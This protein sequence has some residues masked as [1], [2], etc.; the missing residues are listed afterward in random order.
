MLCWYSN[1]FKSSNTTSCNEKN[2]IETNAQV[3][4]YRRWPNQVKVLRTNQK[5][6]ITR[7]KQE[8]TSS[9][10]ET[11]N[12]IMQGKTHQFKGKR[13]GYLTFGLLYQDIKRILKSQHDESRQT[14]NNQILMECM[15]W[16]EFLTTRSSL[17]VQINMWLLPCLNSKD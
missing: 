10:K 9:C 2:N 6:K 17:S 15:S 16:N 14:T 12:I 13:R 8:I 7:A 11:D 4:S 1:R 5:H 3:K